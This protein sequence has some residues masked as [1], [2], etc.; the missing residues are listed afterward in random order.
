MERKKRAKVVEEEGDGEEGVDAKY[1][2]CG[3]QRCWFMADLG[4]R[5]STTSATATTAAKKTKTKGWSMN[6]KNDRW[7]RVFEN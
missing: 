2:L 1:A 3:R 7:G 5:K 6:A 4:C